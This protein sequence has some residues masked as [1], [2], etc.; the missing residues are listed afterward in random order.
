MIG[1]PSTA[2]GEQQHETTDVSLRVPFEHREVGF[3]PR[4]LGTL[5]E[6]LPPHLLGAGNIA[7]Q[8]ACEPERRQRVQKVGAVLHHPLEFF[9]C[10][11]R[12]ARFQERPRQPVSNVGEAGPQLDGAIELLDGLL[13]RARFRVGGRKQGVMVGE[14]GCDVRRKAG[15]VT[16]VVGRSGPECLRR[17]LGP[18]HVVEQDSA[19]DVGFDVTRVEL[20]GPLEMGEG[21]LG[22]TQ[23]RERESQQVV[24]VGELLA[25]VD[26][27]LQQ[28]GWRRNSPG[29]RSAPAPG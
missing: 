20:K 21:P 7:R 8:I 14:I 5:Q 22:L 11:Q 6:T 26:D 12:V 23:Q 17:F 19:M 4:I 28:S 25:A 10:G 16:D 29:A 27:V 3:D 9:P 15:G 24:S 1:C 13:D 18:A 2:G